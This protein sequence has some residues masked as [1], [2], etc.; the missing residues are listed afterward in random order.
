MVLKHTLLLSLCL[1]LLCHCQSLQAQES[2]VPTASSSPPTNSTTA[3]PGITQSLPATETSATAAD[4]DTRTSEQLATARLRYQ[5]LLAGRP[6]LEASWRDRLE[7]LL[8]RYAGW[9]QPGNP[10]ADNP[11]TSNV[12]A[13]PEIPATTADAQKPVRTETQSTT[14]LKT[15]MVA[16]AVPDE[17]PRNSLTETQQLTERL[18]LAENHSAVL[19]KRVAD[20]EARLL[21]L[22]QLLTAATTAL[23]GE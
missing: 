4:R 19:E 18:K 14:S 3:E 6:A 15:L 23:K 10:P 1:P 7:Q 21:R 5:K 9:P 11:S 12:P 20:L 17:L 22:Q 8:A 2:S 13:N 16:T